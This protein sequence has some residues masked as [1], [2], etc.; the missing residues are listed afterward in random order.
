[1]SRITRNHRFILG[2]GL[3]GAIFVSGCGEEKNPPAEAQPKPELEVAASNR[4]QPPQAPAITPS[5]IPNVESIDQA[6]SQPA[7]PAIKTRPE[8][9]HPASGFNLTAEVSTIDGCVATLSRKLGEAV[10]HLHG[11][12]MPST[13]EFKLVGNNKDLLEISSYVLGEQVRTDAVK[14]TTAMLERIMDGIKAGQMVELTVDKSCQNSGRLL[15]ESVDVLPSPAYPQYGQESLL[16]ANQPNG[17]DALEVAFAHRGEKVLS[18]G[19]SGSLSDSELS[20]IPDQ[21]RY[22]IFNRHSQAFIGA[23]DSATKSMLQTGSIVIKD[24]LRLQRA[25]PNLES[26]EIIFDVE[27]LAGQNQGPR[28]LVFDLGKY[29]RDKPQDYFTN[30]SGTGKKCS[31]L[32]SSDIQAASSGVNIGLK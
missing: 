31:E 26:L 10:E 12:P 22:N 24:E 32:E 28:R 14:G 3:L 16:L 13:V 25:L 5:P 7:A 29:C 6:K 30:L 8:N 2:F 20:R 17:K 15:V 4:S 27:H 11:K 1:M 19:F 9:Y 21:I 23:W 18:I